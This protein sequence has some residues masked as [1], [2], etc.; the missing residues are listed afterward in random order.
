MRRI[1][2]I[3]ITI[4]FFGLGA[5][6]FWGF[7][8]YGLSSENAGI[9]SQV[10]LVAVILGWIST[11]V[12][13]AVTQTMTYNQ[14]LIDYKTE[15]LKKQLAEMSPEELAKLQAEVDAESSS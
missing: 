1:D 9:W 10:V 6:A 4:A 14:Q 7:K 11:Y 15:V 12:Y 13:R 2:A 5:F 3:A 8:V